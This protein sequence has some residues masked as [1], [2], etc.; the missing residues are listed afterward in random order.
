MAEITLNGKKESIARA[1]P[2]GDFLESKNIGPGKVVVEI[3]REIIGKEEYATR[4]ICP[5]DSVELVTFVGGG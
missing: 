4:N 3:N 1:V 5:G 2:V